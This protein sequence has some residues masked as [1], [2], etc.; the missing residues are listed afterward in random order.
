MFVMRSTIAVATAVLICAHFLAPAAA[1]QENADDLVRRLKS[2]YDSIISLQARFSQTMSAD[3]FD[4]P[5]R[6]SGTL[7]MHGD[8]YRVETGGQTL[9]TNGVLT[10]IYN[11][12]ENQ[13]LLNDYVEDETTFS[14]NN[15]FHHFDELYV[16]ES[17]ERA[18]VAEVETF[19]MKMTARS[20]DSFFREVT[21]Q[22]RDSD[23]MITR[24]EVVDANET[25][26]AFDLVDI[27]L[28]AP[29]DE[30]TFRFEPTAEMDVVDLRS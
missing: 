17:V 24:L 18:A 14:I 9:V 8:Q 30:E 7:V 29:V 28:N 12:A 4:E 21:V 15:F 10:W 3:Y 22:M 20:P 26:L 27:V 23:D 16:I 19:I 2:K 13:V 1:A 5:E 6:T 11:V 25:H